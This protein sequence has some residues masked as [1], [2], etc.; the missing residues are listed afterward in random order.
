MM[1]RWYETAYRNFRL[2]YDTG[3]PEEVL[4]WVVEGGHV[5]PCRAIDLGCGPGRNAIYLARQGFDVT[6]IDF[7]S[8]AIEKARERAESF[9]LEI[10]F[11]EDDLTNL[12]N[13]SGT[14]QFIVDVGTLDVLHFRIRDRYV[15]SV[16]RLAQPGTRFLLD[17]WEWKLDWWE[18]LLFRRLGVWGAIIEPG[19]VEK[20]FGDSF[21]IE[22]IAREAHQVSHFPTYMIGLQEF[23]GHASYLLTRKSE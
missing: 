4:K 8:S 20:R 13:V 9:G 21:V 22:E 2:P 19:E 16:T 14:F 12:R 7:A 6:G 18:K 23:P 11:V 5:A 15:Q 1:K 17:G 10:E 3:E